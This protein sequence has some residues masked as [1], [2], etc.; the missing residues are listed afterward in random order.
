ML[1][2]TDSI[3]TNLVK[4]ALKFIYSDSL[5]KILRCTVLKTEMFQFYISKA[6]RTVS[7]IYFSPRVKFWL[8]TIV[9]EILL[10]YCLESKLL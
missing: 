8:N 3:F 4:F 6:S 2:F 5:L 10:Q 7:S 1:N 9:L